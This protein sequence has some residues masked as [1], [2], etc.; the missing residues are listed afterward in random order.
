MSDTNKIEIPESWKEMTVEE[1]MEEFKKTCPDDYKNMVE[2]R[3]AS[4]YEA[5]AAKL[6]TDFKREHPEAYAK[7]KREEAA[8]GDNDYIK[9]VVA[10][11]IKLNLGDIIRDANYILDRLND[12]ENEAL[13]VDIADLVERLQTS[14]D[15]VKSELQ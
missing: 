9:P 10:A 4:E 5:K 1:F 13:V 7:M 2:A 14:I 12:V 8:V 6:L 11:E 3:L 15:I